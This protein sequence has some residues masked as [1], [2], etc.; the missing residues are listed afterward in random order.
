MSL[1]VPPMLLR[2]RAIP[3]TPTFVVANAPGNLV[4]PTFSFSVAIPN[5][6]ADRRVVVLTHA[7][8]GSPVTAC[9]IYGVAA[10]L[11]VGQFA[12][13]M[14]QSMWIAHVP[15]GTTGTIFITMASANSFCLDVYTINKLNSQTA[16]DTTGVSSGVQNFSNADITVPG[17]GMVIASRFTGAGGGLTWSA[18]FTE[19]VD[20]AGPGVQRIS[21][22]SAGFNNAQTPL[23]IS[24]NAASAPGEGSFVAACWK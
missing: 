11:V 20:Y 17:G 6:Q 2:G 12:G 23:T 14:S 5:P 13:T 22:A 18:P 16:V 21:D 19:N 4:P 3:A 24:V 8:A 15:T 10:T 7:Y 9:S 1:L